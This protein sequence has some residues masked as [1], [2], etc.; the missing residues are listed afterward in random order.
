MGGALF[1]LSL[2]SLHLPPGDL[3]QAPDMG[4]L[5]VPTFPL[6]TYLLYLAHYYRWSLDWRHPQQTPGS[7]IHPTPFTDLTI[8]LTRNPSLPVIQATQ[9]LW[10]H[11]LSH[12]LHP[13][14]MQTLGA[15]PFY[16]RSNCP[17][18]VYC[19]TLCQTTATSSLDSYTS[20]LP[21]STLNS[22]SFLR[23]HTA[24]WVTL[25]TQLMPLLRS[26]PSS[27]SGSVKARRV[28]AHGGLA[29]LM[30]VFCY[31]S[32]A[33]LQRHCCPSLFLKPTKYVLSHI[34]GSSICICL[35]LSPAS[36]GLTPSLPQACSG[37]ILEKLSFPLWNSSL[38]PTSPP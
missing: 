27:A 35:L 12:T 30:T 38:F 25:L 9:K 8:S 26:H 18:Y 6:Q 7:T 23:T 21:V 10:Y 11:P 19:A 32:C 33:S 5:M 37:L 4:R 31:P 22:L 2:S 1:H 34:S 14:H 3:T 28:S 29:C 13:F 16:P 20:F 24:A 17:R 15:F 36:S